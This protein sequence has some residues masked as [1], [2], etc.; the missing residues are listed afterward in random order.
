MDLSRLGAFGPNVA[1]TGVY[2]LWEKT[3]AGRGGGALRCAFPVSKGSYH[4]VERTDPTHGARQTF[5][6]NWYSHVMSDAVPAQ[7][8]LLGKLL[9]GGGGG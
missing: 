2:N 5:M 4:S 1:K 3:G 6:L 7:P 8:S 9:G